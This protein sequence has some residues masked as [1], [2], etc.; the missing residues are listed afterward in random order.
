MFDTQEFMRLIQQRQRYQRVV[1]SLAVGSMTV[2]MG[3][4][5]LIFLLA[6]NQTTFERLQRV[7]IL[8]TPLQFAFL[9]FLGM[10]GF[11]LLLLP[12]LRRRARTLKNEIFLLCSIP[13][14]LYL[15]PVAYESLTRGWS[16]VPLVNFGIYMI[17]V[18]L[19]VAVYHGYSRLLEIGACLIMLLLM[20]ASSLIFAFMP[21][22]TFFNSVAAALG[23][24]LVPMSFALVSLAAG[25]GFL[26]L[27]FLTRLPV[28]LRR[29]LFSIYASPFLLYSLVVLYNLRGAGGAALIIPASLINLFLLMCLLGF[30]LYRDEESE[31][32]PTKEASAH[33]YS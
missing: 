13:I 32:R 22:L 33:A 23:V 31:R 5:I 16:L 14:L 4:F 26:T 10:L 27:P 24:R 15:L 19:S 29:L 12:D 9:C 28:V 20:L 7:D 18:L 25:L 11:P 21:T 6:P 2:M 17:I 30:A 1:E 3:L 8:I